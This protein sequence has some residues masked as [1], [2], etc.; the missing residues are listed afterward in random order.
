MYIF[1]FEYV[2]K[3]W[4]IDVSSVKHDWKKSK[5]SN[6]YY[7]DRNLVLVKYISMNGLWYVNFKTVLNWGWFWLDAISIILYQTP[8]DPEFYVLLHIKGLQKKV[9]D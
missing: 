6:K 1:Y 7:S 5:S 9:Y 8:F 4:I 3:V 2:N